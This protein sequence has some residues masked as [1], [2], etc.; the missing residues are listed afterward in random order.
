MAHRLGF[1]GRADDSGGDHQDA[2]D[3][4]RTDTTV[5][6]NENNGISVTSNGLA[7]S[8]VTRITASGNGVGILAYGWCKRY[9]HRSSCRQQ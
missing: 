8:G 9:D 2:A 5:T 6:N 3:S 7:V 1:R 4:P